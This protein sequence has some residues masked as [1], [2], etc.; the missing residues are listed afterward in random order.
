MKTPDIFVL[1]WSIEPRKRTL[2]VSKS[3]LFIET[4][5]NFLLFI[6]TGHKIPKLHHQKRLESDPC[7]SLRGYADF[8]L[9]ETGEADPGQ[10][11]SEPR[12]LQP[13][14]QKMM[15]LAAWMWGRNPWRLKIQTS[16]IAVKH[17]LDPINCLTHNNFN[18]FLLKLFIHFNLIWLYL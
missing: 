18:S 4:S 6:A 13:N 12:S 16:R 8:W 17:C 10:N 9:W 3:S 14:L 11:E 7:D 1:S 5:L 2:Q 15:Q